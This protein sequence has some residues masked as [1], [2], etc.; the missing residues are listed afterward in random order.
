[1]KSFE[2][3]GEK[4]VYLLS[5]VTSPSALWPSSWQASS[6]RFITALVLHIWS[7]AEFCFLEILLLVSCYFTLSFPSQRLWLKFIHTVVIS[8]LDYETPPTPC[9]QHL[10]SLFLLGQSTLCPRKGLTH[11]LV[12]HQAL[13]PDH[14]AYILDRVAF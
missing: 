9:Y 1:M 14:V 6:G 13:L 4:C 3:S 8:P 12:M 5:P 10:F 11:P 2:A 7:F